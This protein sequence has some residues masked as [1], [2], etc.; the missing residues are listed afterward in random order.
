MRRHRTP[1]RPRL[2]GALSAVVARPRLW[3]AAAG[4]MRRLVPMRW[5]TRP[6]FLPVPHRDYVRFRLLTALGD[7][8]TA[9]AEPEDLIQWLEWCRRWPAAAAASR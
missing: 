3:V 9:S 1:R 5:W 7:D 8:G 6:P 2:F 4:A